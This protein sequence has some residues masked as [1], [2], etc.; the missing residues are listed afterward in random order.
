MSICHNFLHQLRSGTAPWVVQRLNDTYGPM[1]TD[2][3]LFSFWICLVLPIDEHEK[4]KLLPIRS[5]RLRLRLVVHWI[6]QLNNNWW[7]LGFS[8]LAIR[9]GVGF[10]TARASLVLTMFAL[11][12]ALSSWCG[13]VAD[14]WNSLLMVLFLL[15]LVLG[16]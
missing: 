11:G 5:P 15:P 3:S 12:I 16:L 7:V 2:P 1:P 10:W 13:R 8:G 4:A 14:I 6:E 9:F